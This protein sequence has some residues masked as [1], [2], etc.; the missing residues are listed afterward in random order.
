VIELE[1]R[2]ISSPPYQDIQWRR[3]GREEKDSAVG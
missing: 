2:K 1:K 3:K